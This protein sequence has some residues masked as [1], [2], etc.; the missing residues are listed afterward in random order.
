[1]KGD[2]TNPSNND[3]DIN[4]DPSDLRF[5]RIERKLL[6]VLALCGVQTALLVVIAISYFLPSVFSLVQTLV[7]LGVI[8]FVIY[9]YRKKI[10]TWFGNA[11]RFVFSHLK[12]P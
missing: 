1:M 3:S 8:G 11:S 12:E 4:S 10:P 5:K 2:A 9:A 7:V 6:F